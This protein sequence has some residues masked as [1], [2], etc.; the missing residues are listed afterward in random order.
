MRG[1]L[2]AALA[3][4]LP[5]VGA[6]GQSPIAKLPITINESKIQAT[7][8]NDSTSIVVPI[9]STL[10]REVRAQ[11]VLEWLDTDDRSLASARNDLSILPGGRRVELPLAL[12]K[13]S[14]WLR[15]RYSLIPSRE[16]ALDFAPFSGIVGLTEIAQHVFE[17]KATQVGAPRPGK[18]FIV[19][20]QAVQPVTRKPVDGV[21]YS[22]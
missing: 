17:L 1:T 15:L 16:H 11:L 20:A 8:K 12:P 14:L 19:H 21:K 3:V 2:F 6:R 13:P 22:K 5:L 9:G 4:V 18:P 7:L 10:N